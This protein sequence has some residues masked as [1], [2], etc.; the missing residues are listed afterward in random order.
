M[1]YPAQVTQESIVQQTRQLIEAEGVEQLS[2]SKLA[3]SLGIKA[4]SLYR[5]VRNKNGLLQL[6][7][8]Y[9]LKEM[10]AAF[11]AV[12]SEIEED[13]MG[14]LTAVLHTYRSFAHQ[15]PHGYM[16]AMANGNG[17]QRPEEDVLLQMVLPIQA[18]M[19]QITGE[20]QSLPALRGALALVHGY[21][22]LEL[23]DQ[24]Q[25][26]GDLAEDFE[27]S[28]AAYLRGWQANA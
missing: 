26:G 10:V 21:V 11:E 8:L 15:H 18:I 17:A 27:L 20:A 2:L 24:L 25:R 1:P 16:L 13:A 6:V 22:L 28:V 23:N 4:P 12:L 3:T 9:F 5:H 14:Q 7:N 19:A